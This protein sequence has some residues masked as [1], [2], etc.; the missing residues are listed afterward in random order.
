[1]TDAIA[2][3][4]GDLGAR[5]YDLLTGSG[6]AL[7]G[8]IAFYIDAARRFGTPVL[9]LGVGTGRVAVALAEVGCNVTGLD[10]SKSMLD[11]AAAKVASLPR[12]TADRVRLV[13]GD[14]A[15]FDVDERYP[16]AL[17][18]ARAFQHVLQPAQQRSTL[19]AI[20]RHLTRRGHLVIDLFDPRLDLC[21]PEPVL[22]DP[23]IEVLDPGSAHVIR[24]TTLARINDPLRQVLTETFLLEVVDHTGRVV[25]AE[26]TG[27]SLRWTYRQEMAYLLELCGFEPIGQ[28]ADLQRAPPAY[29][30]EQLWIARAT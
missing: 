15:D 8:D 6:G 21:L 16:L 3:Y 18:P 14:M 29:G 25:K 19:K 30:R 5:T 28:F 9:E 23:P 10:A 12:G 26:E 11:V 4:S 2:Y 22:S 20:H 27:W 24:R 17:I 13:C 1:M 7:A